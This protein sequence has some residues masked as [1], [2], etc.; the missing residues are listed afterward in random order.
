MLKRYFSIN[1]LYAVFIVV[2]LDFLAIG[3]TVPILPAL[4][5]DEARNLFKSDINQEWREI[6]Y[7]MLS[8]VFFLATFIGAPILGALSDKFGRR[9][10]LI[11]TTLSSVIAY[12]IMSLGIYFKIIIPGL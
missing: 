5:K 10:L 8:G 1:P 7:G 6:L 4:F 11:L 2:L 3:L 9:K 12:A